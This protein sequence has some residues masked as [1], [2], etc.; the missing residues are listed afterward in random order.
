QRNCYAIAL[1]RQSPSASHFFFIFV[2]VTTF[3]SSKMDP[4]SDRKVNLV[5]TLGGE[6]VRKNPKK[7]TEKREF[8]RKTSFRPN[9]FFYI[10]VNQKLITVNTFHQRFIVD[11]KML[12][13][14]KNFKFLRNLSKT[15]KFAIF[16]TA[17]YQISNRT[18]KQPRLLITKLPNA[19]YN[20][21]LERLKKKRI[22]KTYSSRME[23]SE[24]VLYQMIYT[25]HN[26]TF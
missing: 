26:S 23:E 24:D 13:D 22:G 18:M 20:S 12:D 16:V 9:Q 25:Q 3:W 8:L 10:V 2:S 21:Y 11:K 19:Q 17:P 7:V 6:N 4:V 14:Q 5:G 15:R 1:P